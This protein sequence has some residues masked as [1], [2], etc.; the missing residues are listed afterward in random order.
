MAMRMHLLAIQ[1]HAGPGLGKPAHDACAG[2][3]WPSAPPLASLHDH[4][5][6]GQILVVVPA[7]NGVWGRGCDEAE[8]SANN[9][10]STER[11]QGIQ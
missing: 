9:V 10:F 7:W 1:S 5:A 11:G 6:L 3:A 4:P 8:I 2:L